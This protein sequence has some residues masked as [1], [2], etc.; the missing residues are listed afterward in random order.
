MHLDLGYFENFKGVDAILISGSRDALN[1]LA[2]R[3]RSLEDDNAEPLGVHALPFA[4]ARRGLE[5]TAYPV[6]VEHG[7][8]R[9]VSTDVKPRFAW[10]HS[11]EGWLEAADKIASVAGQGGH[12]YL[13]GIGAEDAVVIVSDEYDDDWWRHQG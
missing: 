9:V 3:L 13:E 6:D 8:R 10:H 7:I 12:C 2:H 5:L 11:G 4:K 1:E